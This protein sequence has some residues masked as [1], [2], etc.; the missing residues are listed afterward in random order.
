MTSWSRRTSGPQEPG[1]GAHTGE[2]P[3]WLGRFARHLR[4][5]EAAAAVDEPSRWPPCDT[6]GMAELG[7]SGGDHRPAERSC[8]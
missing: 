7:P 3:A 2:E 6:T 5:V 4:D 8:A 1:V